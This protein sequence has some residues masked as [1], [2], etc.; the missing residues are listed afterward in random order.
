[1]YDGAILRLYYEGIL[2][3]NPSQS[4]KIQVY[5]AAPLMFGDYTS[6][7]TPWEYQGYLDNAALFNTA[8]SDGG[9]AVGQAAAP[10]SGIYQLF[11]QGAVSFV[12][13][14]TITN[15]PVR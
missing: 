3:T 9:V 2:R 4:G 6:A 15:A 13:A 11:H 14:M 5:P 10:G 8:L 1:R 12:P 7:V